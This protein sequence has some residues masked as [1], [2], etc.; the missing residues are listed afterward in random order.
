MIYLLN[1]KKK[2][3]IGEILKTLNIDSTYN[4]YGPLLSCSM[5]YVF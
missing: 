3:E 5:T 2:V 4:S 1:E